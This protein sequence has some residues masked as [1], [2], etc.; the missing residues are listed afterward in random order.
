MNEFAHGRIIERGKESVDVIGH[1]DKG[2]LVA[3]FA[4]EMLQR[5]G[6]GL[7]CRRVTESTAANA[8]VEQ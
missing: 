2:E 1:Y 6:D 3:A 7:G 4:F 5:G 8:C